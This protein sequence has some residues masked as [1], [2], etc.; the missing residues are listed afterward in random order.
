MHGTSNPF[1]RKFASAHVIVACTCPP[2]A[3]TDV[4]IL[5][6][7]RDRCPSQPELI[8]LT[9]YRSLLLAVSI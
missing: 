3:K 4:G 6:N 8:M 7:V 2:K 5:E 1:I 9:V